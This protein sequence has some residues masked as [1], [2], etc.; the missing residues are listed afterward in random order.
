MGQAR[1]LFCQDRRWRDS[2]LCWGSSFC[3]GGGVCAHTRA[4]T[5]VCLTGVCLCS[6]FLVE[7]RIHG[8]A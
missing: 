8:S 7:A 2:G 6:F 1:A 5:V 4:P 3:Y